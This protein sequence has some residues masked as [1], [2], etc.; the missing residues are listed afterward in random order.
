MRPQDPRSSKRCMQIEELRQEGMQCVGWYHSHPTFPVL[1]S[2]IDVYNQHTQQ[3]A[4]SQDLPPGV[5][6]PYVAAIVGPYDACN[7]S[8]QSHMSWFYVENRRSEEYTL[9]QAPEMCLHNMVPKLL[10]VVLIEEETAL[11]AAARGVAFPLIQRYAGYDARTDFTQV[12][13]RCIPQRRTHHERD[14]AGIAV[15]HRPRPQHQCVIHRTDHT[16]VHPSA[17][18]LLY[19]I[20]LRLCRRFW[21]IPACCRCRLLSAPLCTI[22]LSLRAGHGPASTIS[23]ALLAWAKCQRVVPAIHLTWPHACRMGCALDKLSLSLTP[24]IPWCFAVLASRLN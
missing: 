20:C 7:T 15:A 13:P 11:T 23:D 24:T 6:A 1:P 8:P 17:N 4:H 9:D 12:C 18:L 16:A 22:C 2:S 3:V 5:P 14:C 19:G 21:C 10:N